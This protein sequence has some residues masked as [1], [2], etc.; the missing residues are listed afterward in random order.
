MNI[1]ELY[2]HLDI[3]VTLLMQKLQDLSHRL[4]VKT[5]TYIRYKLISSESQMLILLPLLKLGVLKDSSAR[6]WVFILP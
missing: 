1:F 4:S 5:H 6:F 3:S 2:S